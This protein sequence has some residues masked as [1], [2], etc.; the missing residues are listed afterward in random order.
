MPHSMNQTKDC[1]IANRPATMASPSATAMDISTDELAIIFGCLGPDDI[2]RARCC[3]KWSEAAKRTIVPLTEFVVNSENRY[4][5]MEAMTRALPNL[6]KI[7]LRKLESTQIRYLDGEDADDDLQI[8][9]DLDINVIS[10][11]TKLSYLEIHNA[12][13]NGIYPMLFHFRHLEMLDI[14]SPQALKW[15]LEMLAGL[16]NLKILVCNFHGGGLSGDIKSLEI[17]KD[18]LEQCLLYSCSNVEGN[19]MDLAKFPH[20]WN[21]CLMDTSVTGDIRDIGSDDFVALQ[22]LDLPD[23]VYGGSGHTFQHISEVPAFMDEIYCIAKRNPPVLGCCYWHLSENSPDNYDMTVS[24]D[25]DDETPEPPFDVSLVRAGS[26]LGWRWSWKGDFINAAP[27]EPNFEHV[28]CEV[29]W[30]DPEP[31]KDSSDYELYVQELKQIEKEINFFKGFH[32]PPTAERYKQL[33]REHK[34]KRRR[35]TIL[36]N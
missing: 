6:Q 21:L 36:I 5:A 28:S 13:L 19:F 15:D 11:F 26:R 7:T 23:A 35:Q 8:D 4:N 27:G 22:E 30:L 17:V 16:P 24:D 32:E 34:R 1:V 10:R 3:K 31:K 14:Y 18:T 20:L 25:V 29:N 9:E 2:M 33:C 12:P